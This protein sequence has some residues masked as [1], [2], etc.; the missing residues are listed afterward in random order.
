MIDN[1]FKK[2]RIDSERGAF[3]CLPE[4]FGR[5][6]WRR[7]ERDSHSFSGMGLLGS[8]RRGRRPHAHATRR[9]SYERRRAQCPCP[10]RRSDQW[11]GYDE[12][13]QIELY[14]PSGL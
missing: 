2:Q 13:L 10:A 9:C 5:R 7:V 12:D 6:R 4:N 8:R 14:R 1:D 3:G 11:A